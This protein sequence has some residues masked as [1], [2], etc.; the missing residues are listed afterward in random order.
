[1]DYQINDGS[2]VRSNKRR[3]E[4]ENEFEENCDNHY[5]KL[6]K[7]NENHKGFQLNFT[8]ENQLNL[9]TNQLA[10]SKI[11]FHD[12]ENWSLGKIIKRELPSIDNIN[13]QTVKHYN[14]VFPP[15]IGNEFF[16]YKITHCLKMDSKY[17]VYRAYNEFRGEQFVIKLGIDIEKLK[18]E[19]DTYQK[20]GMRNDFP[21]FI[22]SFW[23]EISLII[24]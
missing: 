2:L 7:T 11:D 14:A 24:L 4:D 9:I 20:I 16:G 23:Y 6:P 19:L 3:F 17:G 18:F 1:M 10:H 13:A 12:L 15:E 8:L 21:K 22:D 5:Y